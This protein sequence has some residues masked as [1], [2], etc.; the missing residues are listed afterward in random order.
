MVSTDCPRAQWEASYFRQKWQQKER[1][2]E[3]A[4]SADSERAERVSVA[5]SVGDGEAAPCN[6]PRTGRRAK[7]ARPRRRMKRP[8]PSSSSSGPPRSA[9][10]GDP[11]AVNED[12]GA[13]QFEIE[14]ESESESASLRL[15]RGELAAKQSMLDSLTQKYREMASHLAADRVIQSRALLQCQRYKEMLRQKEEE[16]DS[17]CSECDALRT[18]RDSQRLYLGNLQRE[19]RS[20]QDR[21]GRL[22]A[23][24][25]LGDELESERMAEMTA[26]HGLRVKALRSELRR[27]EDEGQR[28]RDGLRAAERERDGLREEVAAL[29]AESGA[30]AMRHSLFYEESGV[31]PED[32][33]CALELIERSKATDSEL[34]IGSSHSLKGDDAVSLRAKLNE[35]QI[36]NRDLVLE[37]NRTQN[38]LE[39]QID[40]NQKLER[41]LDR[42]RQRHRHRPPTS[43]S[44]DEP[45][46]HRI[47][48]LDHALTHSHCDGVSY[49]TTENLLSL[50]VLRGELDPNQLGL[51]SLSM[52]IVDFFHFDSIRSPQLVAG[53][54][55][56]YDLLC[57]FTL[58]M[59]R[60]LIDA[61]SADTASTST[62]T[63]HG[64]P[65]R[66]HFVEKQKENKNGKHTL[67]LS[68]T[69]TAAIDRHSLRRILFHRHTES[70]RERTRKQ[71]KIDLISND[72]R[73]RVVGAL[74]FTLDLLRS[75]TLDDDQNT[76]HPESKHTDS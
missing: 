54:R 76:E 31:D 40:L 47:G 30:M 50:N 23:H 46:L 55:P 10:V 73:H 12:G 34:A 68:V 64:H 42:Q 72:G 17:E 61:L 56:K 2:K 57:R 48:P 67:S 75:V 45:A 20:L 22:T 36:Q 9:A 1:K 8:P 18:E 6:R 70:D 41:D 59:D 69:A 39:S 38:L 43:P 44:I 60:F 14:R 5:V 25:V 19:N 3:S 16:K 62:S 53:H 7:S 11:V 32:L 26:S 29:E 51:P 28:L 4:N 21:M 15:I 33:E 37:C 71:H 52:L 24:S 65:L 35:L 49:R 58:K 66:I 27:R 74:F 13:L 63:D